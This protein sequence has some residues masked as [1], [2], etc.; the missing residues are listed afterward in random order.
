VTQGNGGQPPTTL[1]ERSEDQPDP[2]LV[3]R[4]PEVVSF[5]ALFRREY[6]R[7]VALAWGLTGSRETAEDL[8]QESLLA[9]HRRWD[10]LAHIE[11]P[12]AYV[13][14][15]CANLSVSWIRRR[16]RETKALGRLEGLRGSVST[17]DEST[18]AFWAAVRSLPRRQ[19]QVVAL[20]YGCDLGIDEVAEVLAMAPG[21]VKAHLHRARA[22]LEPRLTDEHRDPGEVS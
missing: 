2:R 7:L 9:L 18:D 16:V 19:A 22:R 20:H 1:G 17:I 13:R 21:T 12:T 10:D 14:R 3:T 5:A 8:A 15:T 4:L 6:P 11:N